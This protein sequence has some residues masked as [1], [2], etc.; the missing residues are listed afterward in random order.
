MTNRII[1]RIKS[2]LSFAGQI[3]VNDLIKEKDGILLQ[4]NPNSN[5]KIWCPIE[6]IQCVIMSNDKIIKG[7]ELAN[8]FRFK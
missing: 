7:E 3:C 1:V 4:T 5:I 6:E 8:E 2:N